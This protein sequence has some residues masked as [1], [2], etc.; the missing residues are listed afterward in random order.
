VRHSPTSRFLLRF[1]DICPT[2]KWGVWS[3]VEKILIRTGVKPIL[4]VVPDN[5]DADLI[6]DPPD[7]SFWERV[8]AWQARGW[9]IGLHGYQHR[10]V[11]NEPGMFGRMGCSEFAGLPAHVQ[12]AKLSCAVEI[13]REHQVVPE[14]WVAPAHS[15]D[16][17]T[18]RA[19]ANLGIRTISDG[20]TLYPY[21]DSN[22]ITWIPQQV[23]RFRK[24]PIGLWTICHH[25][26]DWTSRD[27]REFDRQ[28][29]AFTDEFTCVSDILQSY[30]TRNS[31]WLDFGAAGLLRLGRRAGRFV[32][33]NIRSRHLPS[34][35]ETVLESLTAPR[36]SQVGR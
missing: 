6:V 7:A 3:E 20:Y 5:R 11:T 28:L 34:P 14:I 1:D 21:R 30:G 27:V 2:M 32:R 23:G 8:R 33:E 36:K 24:L 19:L 29:T 12:E 31:T 35:A 9:T 22:G 18:V 17:H 26:N 10:Y 15:L 16:V 13:F 25:T 4:A